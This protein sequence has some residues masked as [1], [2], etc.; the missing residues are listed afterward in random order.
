M[1]TAATYVR[2]KHANIE[3]CNPP[4]RGRFSLQREEIIVK[5]PPMK[6]MRLTEETTSEF[7]I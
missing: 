3:S 4:L 6:N 7:H 2:I 5:G 1:Q